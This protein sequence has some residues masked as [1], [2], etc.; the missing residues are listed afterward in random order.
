VQLEDEFCPLREVEERRA[1]RKKDTTPPVETD[2]VT[3]CQESGEQEGEPPTQLSFLQKD[4][5]YF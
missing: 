5:D 3:A 2:T 1:K 4:E